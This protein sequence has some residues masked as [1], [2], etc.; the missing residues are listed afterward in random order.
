MNIKL[1]VTLVWNEI[2]IFRVI[3]YQSSFIL[4]VDIVQTSDSNIGMNINKGQILF[5]STSSNRG[6]R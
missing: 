1:K 4:E 6:G 2:R 3:V 5:M